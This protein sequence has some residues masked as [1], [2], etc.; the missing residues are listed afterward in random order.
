MFFRKSLYYLLILHEEFIN[1]N[2]LILFNI[3]SKIFYTKKIK[4]KFKFLLHLSINFIIMQIV[5]DVVNIL[6][7]NYLKQ[8]RS[9]L[10]FN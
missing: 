5:F 7:Y 1:V 9:A 8:I 3:S 2:L 10:A 4:I 6:L